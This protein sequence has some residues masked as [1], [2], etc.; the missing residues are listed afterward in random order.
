M[1][2]LNQFAYLYREIGRG[3]NGKWWR[4][5]TIWFG[6]AI[7]VNLS[8]RIDRALFL[9][10]GKSYPLLRPLAFP[11]FL[12]FRGMGCRHD[13]HYRAEIGPGLLVLHPGL[14][15]V[16]SA[17]AVI[18]EN[19]TLTGGNCIG[20]RKKGR[21]LIGKNFSMG[22]NSSVLGPVKIGNNCS[23]GMNSVVTTRCG[24]DCYLFG[25]PAR[26]FKPPN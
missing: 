18:G 17:N 4:Y 11:L 6:G 26:E 25:V 12:L 5:F 9:I 15:V 21:I 14:G 20:G 7:H 22:A 24:D 19:L 8:Y 13:I 2:A 1:E 16:V 10:F 23:L 3:V